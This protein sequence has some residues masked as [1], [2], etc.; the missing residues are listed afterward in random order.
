MLDLTPR[1]NEVSLYLA[2]LEP[3]APSK[4][5]ELHLTQKAEDTS[6]SK[7]Q[8]H[9]YHLRHFLRWCE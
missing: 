8:T 1:G 6:A 3:I 2:K 9:D 5:V 4:A 7:A